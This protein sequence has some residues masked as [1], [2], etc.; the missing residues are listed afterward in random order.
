LL[1]LFERRAWPPLIVLIASI[2]PVW[3]WLAM[4]AAHDTSDA[5]ALIS[6]ATAA[7]VLWRDSANVSH[8]S[9][10]WGATIVL[11][12]I[13]AA[14]YPFVPPLVHAMLAMSALATAC[15]TVW[16][17]RRADLPLWG[18]LLLSLPLIPS[19]NFY[20]G[21]PLRVIVGDVTA[22]LLQM[23]GFAAVRDGA[24]LLWN[25]HQISIDAPCS[26]IKMLWTGM[27]LSCALA[28]LQRMNAGRTVML[29]SVALLIVMM[30]NVLRATALFYVE[31][32]VVPQAQPA[33]A[34]IGVVVFVFAAVAIAV[35]AA[36]L[37]VAAHAN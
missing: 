25:G 8:V 32:G 36:R 3:Q 24:T 27:Y 34:M 5:W 14:S 10:Q 9:P 19:L 4:R 7:A 1:A 15:S 22:M 13:Y 29:G 18:L 26:G 2:W 35:A 31:A 12:L 11:M 21:Y 17:G 30:A 20:L 6:L 28:A 37:R 16:F 33:H 23:N